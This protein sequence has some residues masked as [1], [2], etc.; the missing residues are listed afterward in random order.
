[1]IVKKSILKLQE[2]EQVIILFIILKIESVSI[3]EYKLQ[4]NHLIYEIK[5]EIN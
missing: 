1:M 3:K 2:Y 4:G 5:R